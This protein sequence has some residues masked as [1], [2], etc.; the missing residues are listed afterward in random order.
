MRSNDTGPKLATL[1]LVL[2]LAFGLV[3]P[4]GYGIFTNADG[5]PPENSIEVTTVWDKTYHILDYEVLEDGTLLTYTEYRKPVF[6]F[7]DIHWSLAEKK[8]SL[9]KGTYTL[10][11][12]Q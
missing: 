6:V 9:P 4:V 1:C 3:V 10:G 8:R 5:N 7:W 12:V 2:F 11:E